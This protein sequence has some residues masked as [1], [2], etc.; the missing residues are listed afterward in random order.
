MN[1]EKPAAWFGGGRG[2]GESRELRTQS[3]KTLVSIIA[4]C[5]HECETSIVANRVPISLE[6]CYVSLPLSISVARWPGNA[7]QNGCWAAD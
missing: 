1:T 6:T 3:I 7:S 5:P 4:S 2:A